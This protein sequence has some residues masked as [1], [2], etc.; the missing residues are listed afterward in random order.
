LTTI[1]ESIAKQAKDELAADPLVAE[2]MTIK[3]MLLQ[4]YGVV[5]PQLTAED[6]AW[7]EPSE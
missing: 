4:K 2:N 1:E 6:K 7:M 3:H 5:P